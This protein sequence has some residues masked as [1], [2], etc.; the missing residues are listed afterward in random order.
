[1]KSNRDKHRDFCEKVQAAGAGERRKR[2]NAEREGGDAKGAEKREKSKR[3][4]GK[5]G[6]REKGRGEREGERHVARNVGRIGTGTLD[7]T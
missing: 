6:K 5:K 2:I 1:M 7:W 4:K 3:E